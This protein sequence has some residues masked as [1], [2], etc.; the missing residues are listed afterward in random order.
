MTDAGP[1]SFNPR[2]GGS[3]AV[4]PVVG[5]AGGVGATLLCQHLGSWALDNGRESP[6]H[7]AMQVVL[8]CRSTAE[9]LERAVAGVH[10]LLA[11]GGDGRRVYL[12]VVQDGWGP[13]PVAARA[14]LRA[15]QPYLAGVVRVP[16]VA[17]WRYEDAPHTVPSRAYARAVHRLT[18]LLQA[19]PDF[20]KEVAS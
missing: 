18:D 2:T 9:G 6:S 16:H 13:T 5:C 19:V 17:H 20:T 8:V 3:H 4:V 11:T 14:R 15:L 12:A 10:R 1:S 7:G